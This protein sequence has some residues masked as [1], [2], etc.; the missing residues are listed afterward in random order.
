MEKPPINLPVNES[1]QLTIDIKKNIQKIRE[2]L[3]QTED[4][5][6]KEMI[7]NNQGCTILFLDSMVKKDIL[8]SDIIG[9]ILEMKSGEEVH[10]VV[11]ATELKFS[12]KISEVWASLLEGFCTIL[13]ENDAIAKSVA[14]GEIA[15]RSIEEPANERSIKSSHDGF[16]ENLGHFK[17]IRLLE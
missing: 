8:Q 16:V 15:A 1:E 10:N 13:I 9:P 3:C 6:V 14:V 11:K 4:L 12:S 5:M 17:S 7:F 2:Y